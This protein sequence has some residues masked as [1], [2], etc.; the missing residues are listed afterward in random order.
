MKLAVTPIHPLFVAN[1]TGVEPQFVYR[2]RWQVGDL[3]IWD[4]RCT[5]HRATPFEAT[6]HVRDM[7]RTT[8]VD[9]AP[10]AVAN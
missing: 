3:V 1:V 5:T 6:D 7:R 9:R 4:N 10:E 8:I 2:H